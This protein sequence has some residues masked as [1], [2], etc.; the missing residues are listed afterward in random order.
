MKQHG[1]ERCRSVT[2]ENQTGLGTPVDDGAYPEMRKGVPAP[3]FLDARPDEPIDTPAKLLA[4]VT[5]EPER[6]L[7]SRSG[8]IHLFPC[9]PSGA[10]IGFREFQARGGFLVSAEMLGGQITSAE[11]TARRSMTCR[12]KNPWSGCLVAVRRV[13]GTG[14]VTVQADSSRADDLT[15]AAQAGAVY[16]LASPQSVP[17]SVYGQKSNRSQTWQG[18]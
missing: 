12:L 16:R 3:M 9:V 5:E 14:E 18:K 15:F 2:A 13:D 17:E 7:N 11:I 10:T 1:E 8:R 6:L 4:A